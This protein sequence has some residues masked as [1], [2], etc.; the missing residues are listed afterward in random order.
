MAPQWDPQT[1]RLNTERYPGYALTDLSSETKLITE[2]ISTSTDGFKGK[3]SNLLVGH[4]MG[5]NIHA[6][7]HFEEE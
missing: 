4:V 5:L 1:L 7:L 3:C 2:L 6:N